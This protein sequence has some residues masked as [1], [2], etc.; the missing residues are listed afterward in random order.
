MPIQTRKLPLKPPVEERK[1]KTKLWYNIQN[2]GDGSVFLRWF[3]SKEL[4]EIDE[5]FMDEGWGECSV[6]CIVIESDSPIRIARSF[7]TV[8]TIESVE[9]EL[10]KTLGENWYSDQTRKLYEQ[11]LEA[12]RKLK[13]QIIGKDS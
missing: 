13:G 2:G 8:C 6:D 3:E 7:G 12:V 5:E 4:S 11:K 10:I 1:M 9:A